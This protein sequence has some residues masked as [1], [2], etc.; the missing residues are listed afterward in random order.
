MVN[1]R[2]LIENWGWSREILSRRG[3]G[4]SILILHAILIGRKKRIWDGSSI[5]YFGY[6]MTKNTLILLNISIMY[7]LNY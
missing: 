3:N 4:I 1:G 2:A 5:D 6:Y 7:S